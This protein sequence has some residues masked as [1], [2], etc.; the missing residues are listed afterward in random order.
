MPEKEQIQAKRLL[1][2]FC[3]KS[4]FALLRSGYFTS[5]N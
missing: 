2:V 3:I 1:M 5:Q 4:L